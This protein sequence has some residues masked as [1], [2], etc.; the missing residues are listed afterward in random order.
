MLTS[1]LSTTFKAIVG[2]LFNSKV[3][4]F[5]FFSFPLTFLSVIVDLGWSVLSSLCG[6]IV[7]VYCLSFEVYYFHFV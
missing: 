4:F 1:T 5:R 6:K 3:I 7:K 2:A